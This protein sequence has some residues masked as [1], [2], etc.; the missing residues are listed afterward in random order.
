MTIQTMD[1]YPSSSKVR[2]MHAP[3][4]MWEVQLLESSG[5][6]VCAYMFR[7]DLAELYLAIGKVLYPDDSEIKEM[8][9]KIDA[10]THKIDQ[11]IKLLKN[12]K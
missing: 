1:I 5:S 9:S 4:P 2:F 8:H 11:Q 7:S 12:E 3:D 6:C 10:L